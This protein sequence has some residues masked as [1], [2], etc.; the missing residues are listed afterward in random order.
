[1]KVNRTLIGISAAAALFCGGPA[2]AETGK[3]QDELRTELKKLREEVEQLKAAKKG[4]AEKGAPEG[5]EE[6]LTVPE[7]MDVLELK[8]KDAV[9]GG[10]IGNSFRLPGTETSLHLYGFAELNYV[11]EFRADNA[12]IDYS[13]FAPYLP[14]YGSDASN[15]K[16]RDY[17]TART[18]RIGLDA[19]TPT[20]FGPLLVKIE[21]DFNNNP[22]TGNTELYGRVGDIYTQ[23]VT[24]SYGFR[25]RQAYGSF[26]GLLAGMTWSTFMDVDNSP[27]TVDFNGPI[28]A[29]FIRQAQV[30]YTYATPTWGNFTVAL[31]NSDSYVLQQDVD[32]NG[33][34]L[35]SAT[36]TN[37]GFSRMPD[38]VARW[39]GSFD[40]GSMSAR[41]MTQEI[42]YQPAGSGNAASYRGYGLAAT[43]LVKMRDNQDYLSLGVTFGDGIGRYMNY[44]EGAFYDPA[45]KRIIVEE[46]IGAVVGYQYKPTDWLRVN[47]AGGF[48]RNFD[49][50]YTAYARSI[51]VDSGRFGINRM[52]RQVH[53][54][55]IFTPIKTV[56]LG[57]E[58]IW[59][60]RET[61][62]GEKGDMARVNFS[63]KYYIN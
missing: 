28:G 60:D 6:A 51:G 54:G 1:M 12:D 46:A 15:R 47:L 3:E 48:T 32:A 5:K 55:P 58:G 19:A 16:G 43:A 26:A 40:W 27:E 42:R 17:L 20:K 4:E 56:D 18:S 62:K 7:R 25:I 39:D 61:L 11:H 29:T 23:Q 34:G 13:T 33:V 41:A 2:R 30:R 49:N 31:E 14:L 36:A 50:D 10:D 8:Q 38:L 63:A 57:V 35:P 45:T 24:S 21:G 9:V 59:G 22:S 37:A 53:L 44:I 52:V